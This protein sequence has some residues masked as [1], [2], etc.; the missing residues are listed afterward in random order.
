MDCC[1]ESVLPQ[2]LMHSTVGRIQTNNTRENLI[3]GQFT[4]P[5]PLYDLIELNV[6]ILISK[7][8]WISN[9]DIFVLYLYRTV[10]DTT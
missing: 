10:S 6:G 4:R 5:R 3:F 1:V 2:K 8:L 7:S 9:E